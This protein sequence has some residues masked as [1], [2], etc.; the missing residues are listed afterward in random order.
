MSK[1]QKYKN[2]ASAQAAR[3]IN[4]HRSRNAP[5]LDMLKE[6]VGCMACGKCNIQGQYLDCHHVDERYKFKPLAWMLNKPWRRVV[7]ELFGVDREKENGGGPT[8]ILCQRYHEDLHKYGS[9]ARKCP[10]LEKEGF[11]E[12]WRIHSRKPRRKQNKD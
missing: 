12:P 2:N 4:S 9:D 7:R 8:E 11:H 6:T 10:E 5:R 1:Q 3:H